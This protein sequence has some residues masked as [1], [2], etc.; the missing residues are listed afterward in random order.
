[1]RMSMLQCVTMIQKSDVFF[2]K[3]RKQLTKLCI[4]IVGKEDMLNVPP[5]TVV[6]I[7][8]KTLA[9]EYY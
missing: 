6:A 2:K 3:S 5:F 9:N 1:M 8:N 4:L 7:E